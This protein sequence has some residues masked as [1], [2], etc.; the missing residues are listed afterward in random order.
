MMPAKPIS[1]S[2]KESKRAIHEILLKIQKKWSACSRSDMPCYKESYQENTGVE[3]G[4][5][6]FR[7]EKIIK[8]TVLLR[9]EDF[10]M[11]SPP[12][13]AL[14]KNDL[15]KT[16]YVT[17][18]NGNEDI[19]VVQTGESKEDIPKTAV[20]APEVLK[21]EKSPEN[22]EIPETRIFSNE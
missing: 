4:D 12:Q 21:T 5:A 10:Q 7:N 14:E 6:D 20:Y 11:N 15:L 1:V 22:D 9:F 17:P 18:Q 19:T 8:E 2:K 16:E 13:K 3:K